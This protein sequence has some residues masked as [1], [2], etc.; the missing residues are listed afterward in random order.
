MQVFQIFIH[1][2][3][4]DQFGCFNLGIQVLAHFYNFSNFLCINQFQLFK[5]TLLN[6][7]HC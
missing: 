4:V 2:A 5:I 7:L 3:S 6:S 1:Y